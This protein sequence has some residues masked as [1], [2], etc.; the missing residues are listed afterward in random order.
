MGAV[1]GGQGAVIRSLQDRSGAAIKVHNNMVQGDLKLFTIVGTVAQY[2]AAAHLVKEIVDRPRPFAHAASPAS[3]ERSHFSVP[4]PPEHAQRTTELYKT[5]YVPTSF[6]GLVIGRN[7]DTIRSLQDKSGADIKVTPDEEAPVGSDERSIQISGTDEA[8]STAH[9]LLSEIVMDARSRR[10]PSSALPVGSTVNGHP[11]LVEVL[12]VPNEKVG[13]IIGKHGTTIRDLQ[14]KSG[15]KIQVTKDESY[16]Q[17]DGSRPVTITGVRTSVDDAKAMIASKINLP[18]LSSGPAT[19]PF[20]GPPSVSS[21]LPIPTPPPVRYAFSPVY[22]G[23]YP[24]PAAPFPPVFDPNDAN[25]QNR[26]NVAYFQYVGYN[27]YPALTQHHRQYQQVMPYPPPHQGPPEQTM[28]SPHSDQHQEQDPHAP[29]TAQPPYSPPGPPQPRIDDVPTSP[30]LIPRDPNGN[31]IL[32]PSHAVQQ[33]SHQLPTRPMYPPPNPNSRVFL[34]PDHAQAVQVHAAHM[35]AHHAQ[36][37]AH[38][39]AAQIQAHAHAHA[40]AHVQAQNEPDADAHIQ[41]DDAAAAAAAVASAPVP[42]MPSAPADD[43]KLHA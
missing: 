16:V 7:G 30:A 21:V 38:A 8:I 39:Q 35:Y 34:H 9:Q 10:P 4:F 14:A 15:A 22:E 42:T 23:D 26:A 33:I 3:S 36:A 31:P 6:V 1:I 37:H 25:S 27:N 12:A 5:V 32:Y 43:E 24:N 40:Q 11:V 17:S 28:H 13:L 41:P 20:A 18:I 19:A 29:H 2:E